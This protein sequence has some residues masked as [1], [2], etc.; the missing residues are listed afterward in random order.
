[1]TC[2]ETKESKER[3]CE[4][5]TD[6]RECGAVKPVKMR[7]AIVG[8]ENGMR[9][10]MKR[11]RKRSATKVGRGKVMFVVVDNWLIVPMAC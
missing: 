5:A 8:N 11:E 9:K 2:I 10:G 3:V 6:G 4:S 7:R 1:M